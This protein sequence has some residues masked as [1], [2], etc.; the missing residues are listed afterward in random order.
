[1]KRQD[2][3][4]VPPDAALHQ[5]EKAGPKAQL[6][7]ASF[8]RSRAPAVHPS[9]LPSDDHAV[10]TI[11][12][13]AGQSVQEETIEFVQTHQPAL[14]GSNGRGRSCCRLGNSRA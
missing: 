10:R 7:A 1:V 12:P 3:G 4:L 2:H 13:R 9:T 6:M 8:T 14:C 5:P 11:A